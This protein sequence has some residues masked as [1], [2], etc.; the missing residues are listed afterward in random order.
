V[1]RRKYIIGVD[2]LAGI[3]QVTE[4]FCNKYEFIL[5]L[6]Y[7]TYMIF[8]DCSEERWIKVTT[9]MF[10]LSALSSKKFS[11]IDNTGKNYLNLNAG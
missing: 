2:Y 7:K 10:I 5:K 3:L 6:S 4:F 8:I 11:Y 1:V 9:G